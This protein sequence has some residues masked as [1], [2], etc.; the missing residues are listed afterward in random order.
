MVLIALLIDGVDIDD[1]P[2]VGVARVPFWVGAPVTP[3]QT[4]VP[5]SP[6]QPARHYTV[7][8][9]EGLSTCGVYELRLDS[10]PGHPFLDTG[11]RYPSALCVRGL[12]QI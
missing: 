5:A 3:N 4:A 10:S 9:L 1:E 8:G 2:R 6:R 12:D 7:V 11:C